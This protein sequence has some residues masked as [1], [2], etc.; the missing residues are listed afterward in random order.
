MASIHD[1]SSAPLGDPQKVT[2]QQLNCKI[3]RV[4]RLIQIEYGFRPEISDDITGLERNS[5]SNLYDPETFE[6]DDFWPSRRLP[7]PVQ[8]PEWTYPLSTINGSEPPARAQRYAEG[9]DI[10]LNVKNGGK[11]YRIEKGNRAA[12]TRSGVHIHDSGGITWILD[13]ADI[14]LYAQ[15]ISPTTFKERQRY[16][17]PANTPMSANNLSDINSELMD[18]FVYPVGGSPITVLEPGY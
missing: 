1:H 9:T 17:M 7:D 12:G 8:P 4:E 15:G 13:G 3:N 5:F 16:Y 10:L 6:R 11:V 2:K 18:L 14:T